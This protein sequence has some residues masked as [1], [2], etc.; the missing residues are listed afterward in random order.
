MTRNICFCAA[1]TAV[2]ISLCIAATLDIPIYRQRLIVGDETRGK[3]IKASE[4][5]PNPVWHNDTIPLQK[6]MDA[7]YFGIIRIGSPA[8]N[9]KMVFNTMWGDTWIPSAHCGLFEIACMTHTR[10]DS[11]RS[12]S[13][14]EDGTIFSTGDT[15][16]DLQGFVSR[17]KFR[18][19]HL[20]IENQSFIEMTHIPWIPYGLSKADGIIGLGFP[21]LRHIKAPSFFTNMLKQ[22]LINKPMFSF[23]FNRDATTERAGRLVLGAPDRKHVNEST[24]VTVPV[25]GKLYWKIKMDRM[26]IDVRNKSHPFCKDGCEA[27][28]DSSTNT[29]I[30]PRDEIQLINDLLGARSFVPAIFKMD[31]Y[32]VNCREFAK[33]PPID[34]KIAEKTFTINSKYYV[35]HLTYESLE[36]CLSPFVPSDEKFWQLG[37]AFLMEFYTEYNFNHGQVTIGKTKF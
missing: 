37:G 27:L 30:G 4:T 6:F 24:L 34:F 10:Y 32:M 21:D 25:I 28:L 22:K 35:Q 18:L 33:L 13:Y 2:L 29:I 5:K 7:E 20:T 31:R 11:S 14:Q 12:S 16:N 8:K 15:A 9:F 19:D 17:D 23:Y 1:I 26:V 3:S 36:I